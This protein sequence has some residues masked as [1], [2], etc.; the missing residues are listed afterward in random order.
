MALERELAT[1]EKK[2]PELSAEHAGEYALVHGDEIVD[3]FSSY[4]D[5]IKAGYARF[6]LE[7]FL[8]KQVQS[9]EPV[10][11]IAR[12]AEPV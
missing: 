11:F 5:A 9:F 3:L 8:V 1:F 4:D 2:L 10:H 7:A 12:P 6:G